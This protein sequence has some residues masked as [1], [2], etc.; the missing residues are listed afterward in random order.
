MVSSN[1]IVL[2]EE[3][4]DKFHS[5]ICSMIPKMQANVS[6]EKYISQHLVF[7][8]NSRFLLNSVKITILKSQIQ[9]F[10]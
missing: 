2:A 7:E 8:A 1:I 9:Y 10:S 5:R 6:A 3:F 4:T